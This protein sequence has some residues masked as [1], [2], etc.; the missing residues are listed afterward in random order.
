MEESFQNVCIFYKYIS[1]P[2]WN[3]NIC[4]FLWHWVSPFNRVRELN[5]MAFITF[6][7][8]APCGAWFPSSHPDESSAP[9]TAA[10]LQPL[11][12]DRP[13]PW[14]AAFP[15]AAH[16]SS[17]PGTVPT[18][19][20]PRQP[21]A[22]SPT[23]GQASRWRRARR[24]AWPLVR[25]PAGRAGHVQ[26]PSG[27]S[28]GLSGTG[29][30]RSPLHQAPGPAA[31]ACFPHSR[32]CRFLRG[33]LH[34]TRRLWLTRCPTS[35]CSLFLPTVLT[36]F[37][38]GICVAG[39]LNVL[40]WLGAAPRTKRRA[41]SMLPRWAIVNSHAV[42]CCYFPTDKWLCVPMKM[43]SKPSRVVCVLFSFFHTYYSLT[44]LFPCRFPKTPRLH[45]PKDNR[46]QAVWL[47]GTAHVPRCSGVNHAPTLARRLAPAAPWPALTDL[48]GK[49]LY[50][51]K[52]NRWGALTHCGKLCF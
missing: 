42:I 27:P 20:H 43:H 44:D 50:T 38:K 13:F 15:I 21:A 46:S 33:W 2:W 3:L 28:V 8:S 29:A 31:P 34:G 17:P 45:S 24:G 11:P 40:E 6:E 23:G 25:A 22:Q 1:Y 5:N 18:P 26:V 32:A 19:A 51:V 16:T 47:P 37:L 14:A 12:S 35:P 10:V 9:P 49:Y 52:C 30:P 4:N 36:A 7:S 39:K 48:S 41:G